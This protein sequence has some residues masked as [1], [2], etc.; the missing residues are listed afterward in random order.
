MVSGVSGWLARS[1]IVRIAWKLLKIIRS[2]LSCGRRPWRSIS[3]ATWRVVE[4]P[5]SWLELM[6]SSISERTR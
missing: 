4:A 3:L 1:E 5:S 6:A 2:L